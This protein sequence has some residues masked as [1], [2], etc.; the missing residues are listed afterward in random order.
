VGLIARGKSNSSKALDRTSVVLPKPTL[1]AVI[2]GRNSG[3]KEW[4]FQER[5]GMEQ[6]M[7]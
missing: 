3:I 2:A 5:A 4:E 6:E 7:L 1:N